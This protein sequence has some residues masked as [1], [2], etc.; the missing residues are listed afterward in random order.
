MILIEDLIFELEHIN[1]D[2]N[3]T[4]LSIAIDF[5]KYTRRNIAGRGT[6]FGFLAGDEYKDIKL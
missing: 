4:A 5:L 6:L 3:S 2:L 1:E